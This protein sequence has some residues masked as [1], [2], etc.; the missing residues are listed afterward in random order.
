MTVPAFRL[1]PSGY[2]DIGL[3]HW[4]L[5]ESGAFDPVGRDLADVHYSRR[6]IGAPQFL[7]PGQRFVLISRDYRSVWGWHRPHPDAGITAMNGLDGWTCCIFRR[8]GGATL[9]SDL[10]LDAE[11]ALGILGYDCGPSGLITYIW[12]R[13]VESPN[14][15]YSY[16]LA[17]WHRVGKKR[18]CDDCKGWNERSA[19][20]EKT[21]LHKPFAM[22][23]KVAA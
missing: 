1:S 3:R 8:S 18:G 22:A 11:L 23:G 17:G 21:L 7:P 13:K 19:D 2:E 20:G 16:K 6:T 9:A 14:P 10:I 15:G 4:L 12:D 5:S